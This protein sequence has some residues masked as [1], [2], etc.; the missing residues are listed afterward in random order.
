MGIENSAVNLYRFVQNM[1][2]WVGKRLK[3]KFASI[4][5]LILEATQPFTI[6]DLTSSK[7]VW[8]RARIYTPIH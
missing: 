6:V 8:Q 5:P 1:S 2:V 7:T 3:M 4:D